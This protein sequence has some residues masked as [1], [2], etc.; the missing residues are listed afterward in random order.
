MD[1][2]LRAFVDQY[3]RE[4][5]AEVREADGILTV[6]FPPGRKRRF[7]GERRFTFDPPKSAPGIEVL[8]PGSP[9][10]KLMFVD[11]KQW[12]G[13][14]AAPSANLPLGSVVFTFQFTTFSSLKKRT[15][16]VTATLPPEA[17]R[18]A[19]ADGIAE[20]SGPDGSA[21]T[22]FPKEAERLQNLLPMVMPAIEDAARDFGRDAVAEST[23]EFTKSLGRV[24]EYF[25]GLR[26]QTFS[27]EARI[28]KRLGEIQ[29]KLYFAEDGLRQLKLEK[30][31][32]R[33]TQDLYHL[34]QRRTQAE[35][36][37]STDQTDHVERQRRRH[38]P[39]LHVRLVAATIVAPASKAPPPPPEPEPE[40]P[41][42]P[43]A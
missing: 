3:L 6:V 16:F 11:A 38:E 30:E 35:D 25:E 43:P 28:R 42:A 41:P 32:D 12:G 4:I 27:E 23:A 2:S 18:P 40:T 10:L 19:L 33:L 34:K 13:L 15:K 36:K 14:A 1:G 31:R 22:P 20:I 39:K 7:G 9:L 17:T 26:Q 24:N 8:E 5:G 21:E 29:S 37:L